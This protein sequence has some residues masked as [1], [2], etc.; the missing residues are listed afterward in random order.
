LLPLKARKVSTLHLYA[1]EPAFRTVEK[2][3]PS[4]YRVEA[5][6]ASPEEA[7]VLLRPILPSDALAIVGLPAP[8]ASEL[9]RCAIE[10]VVWPLVPTTDERAWMRNVAV[11]GLLDAVRNPK[12]EPGVDLDY[13]AVRG[14]LPKERP[15]LAELRLQGLCNLDL[16][17]AN[18]GAA[19]TNRTYYALAAQYLAGA[20]RSGWARKLLG[21]HKEPQV[22]HSVHRHSITAVHRRQAALEA[23]LGTDWPKTE[24]KFHRLCAGIDVPM[25]VQIHL[26]Q[27]AGPRVLFASPQADQTLVWMQRF[28]K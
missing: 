7:H 24:S 1:D 18:R 11:A 16:P 27:R 3:F 13:D 19:A 15:R 22:D 17:A 5:C 10:Q 4:P 23:V 12:H 21:K 2:R 9:Q 6:C 14:W 20:D 26:A 25:Y 8:T 28:R